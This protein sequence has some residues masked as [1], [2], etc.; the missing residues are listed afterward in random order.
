MKVIKCI[1][2]ILCA[3]VVAVIIL[4]GIMCF[5]SLMP[6]HHE[7]YNENT[8]YTYTPNSIWVKFTE[9]ISWGRFDS[10][11]YNNPEVV[12]NPD[13]IV[14][15]SSHMESV[16]VFFNESV[17]GRLKDMFKNRYTVY[18]MGISGHNFF[19]VCQYLPVN[20][21]KYEIPPKIAIIET[22]NLWI[23]KNNV[24]KVF[25][26]EVEHT[27]SHDTGILA[28]LQRVPFFRNIYQQIDGGLLN[29]FIPEREND[30]VDID[31]EPY[32]I[33]I[34]IDETAYDQLFKYLSD[35]E[36]EYGTQILIFNHPNGT[37]NEDGSISF[38]NGDTLKYFRIYAEKYNIDFID[39]TKS[40][41][42]MYDNNHLLSHGFVTGKVG[43]GHLNANGHK[44]IANE[45]YKVIE[46]ME[47]EG[48][49]CK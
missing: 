8:D 4:S 37:L 35:L 43:V 9:G 16:N 17:S 46:R 14:L 40:F 26:H 10:D 31:D 48:L 41:K 12:N 45:L 18:N 22:S 30:R 36:K 44:A 19:K 39:M 33:K 5:Y 7:N 27:P 42:E 6:L 49:L 47:K 29:V 25:K 32:S 11:G 24:E 15:G 23:S 1:G 28:M 34:T 13:I 21:G 20:L 3:G 38:D 2:K